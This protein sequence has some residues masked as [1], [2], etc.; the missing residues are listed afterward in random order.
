MR[1]VHDQTQSQGD[2]LSNEAIKRLAQ[3]LTAAQ[4]AL[5]EIEIQAGDNDY[6]L[7]AKDFDERQSIAREAASICLAERLARDSHFECAIIFGGPAWDILL[8]VFVR[9]TRNLK[10]TLDDVSKCGPSAQLSL[11][12]FGIL[13][14]YGLVC[15]LEAA[16]GSG[17]QLVQMTNNGY[18]CMTRYFSEVRRM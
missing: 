2:G 8:A 10:T 3:H 9:Q 11:R 13:E 12:W 14:K 5:C 15:S 4:E 7:S 17:Q 6:P 16:E 1:L 18:E